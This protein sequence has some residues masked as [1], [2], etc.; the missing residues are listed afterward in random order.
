M[1]YF[2]EIK[3]MGTPHVCVKL[4]TKMTVN[5]RKKENCRSNSKTCV[6]VIFSLRSH[7]YI[8]SSSKGSI[9]FHRMVRDAFRKING[10]R[11]EFF[12]H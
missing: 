12:P 4:D 8:S 3:T 9:L 2:A 7:K 10:I 1:I 11:W 5:T 6:V